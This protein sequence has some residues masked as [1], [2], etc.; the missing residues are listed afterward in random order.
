MRVAGATH[1]PGALVL[2]GDFA[3]F[4]PSDL[5]ARCFPAVPDARAEAPTDLGP[6]RTENVEVHLTLPAGWRASAPG[7]PVEVRSAAG[8]YTLALR[9]DGETLVLSRTCRRDVRLVGSKDAAPFATLVE[10]ARDAEAQPIVLER[11]TP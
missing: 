9:L 11:R 6:R 7:A 5:V 1:R 3:L 4:R 8:A 10:A 2:R